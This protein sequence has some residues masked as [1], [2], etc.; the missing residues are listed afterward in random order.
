VAEINPASCQ[1]C[2][3]CTSACP[4]KAIQLGSYTDREILAKVEALSG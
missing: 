1:G 3:I 2:G 4:R